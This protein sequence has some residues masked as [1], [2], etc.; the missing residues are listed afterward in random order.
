MMVLGQ[1][2]RVFSEWWLGLVKYNPYYLS[3]YQALAIYIVSAIACGLL[4]AVVGSVS[5]AISGRVTKT[6]TT[7]LS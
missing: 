5:P 6:V 2:S 1:A 7:T 4:L 3:S